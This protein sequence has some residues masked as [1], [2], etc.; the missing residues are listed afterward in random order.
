MTTGRVGGLRGRGMPQTRRAQHGQQRIGLGLDVM[1]AGRPQC[2]HHLDCGSASPHV[3]ATAPAPTRSR[4]PSPTDP[5]KLR[6]LPGSIRAVWIS[7]AGPDGS[8]PR[9]R[10]DARGPT[11]SPHPPGRCPRRSTGDDRDPT[12][13]SPRAHEHRRRPT[14]RRTWSTAPG[15]APRT[16]V[17]R[18]YPATGR[19][20]RRHPRA[21]VGL[22][23]DDHPPATSSDGRSAQSAGERCATSARNRVMPSSPSGNRGPRQPPTGLVLPLEVVVILGPVVPDEQHPQQLLC[24]PDTDTAPGVSAAPDRPNP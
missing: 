15:T 14:S 9:W 8:A 2:R 19:P 23:P 6:P 11:A 1:P 12:G 21:A 7:V 10:S 24:S 13:R 20:Q 16:T 22:D 18:E 4:R 3:W 17:D 5:R